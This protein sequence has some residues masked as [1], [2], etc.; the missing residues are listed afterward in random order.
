MGR[1]R[2]F[3]SNSMWNSALHGDNRGME[4]NYYERIIDNKKQTNVKKHISLYA[5]NTI[6]QHNYIHKL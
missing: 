4:F 6:L 3:T 1:T 5:K 2:I